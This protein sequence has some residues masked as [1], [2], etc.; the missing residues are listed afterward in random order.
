MLTKLTKPSN[1]QLCGWYSCGWCVTVNVDRS[2]FCGC[3]VLLWELSQ[4][5]QR[6]WRLC[7][8]KW[9]R[10]SPSVW[11]KFPWL[12]VRFQK[13]EALVSSHCICLCLSLFHCLHLSLCQCLVFSSFVF[14]FLSLSLSIP[15]PFCLSLQSMFCICKSVN[16]TG[17]V[18]KYL[19]K[20]L[21]SY[22]WH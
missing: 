6:R 10:N 14:L 5:H 15:I 21:P 18:H 3:L 7:W 1:T 19:H 17:V 16:L 13:D 11:R 9:R 22:L 2:L 4:H 20:C 8:E 12:R